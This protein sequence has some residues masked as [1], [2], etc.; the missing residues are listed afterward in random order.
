LTSKFAKPIKAI[1]L[2]DTG[3]YKTMVNPDLFPADF[4]V[5]SKEQ[6]QAANGEIFGA[7][8]ISKHKLGIKFFS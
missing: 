1:G 2:I 8:L 6:F 5:K 7:N 3:A 4:W